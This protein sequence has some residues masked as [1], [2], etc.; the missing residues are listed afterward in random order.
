LDES[1]REALGVDGQSAGVGAVV[2]K[3]GQDFHKAGGLY[4]SRSQ[5]ALF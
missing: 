4:P 2:S 3:N 5:I 1:A